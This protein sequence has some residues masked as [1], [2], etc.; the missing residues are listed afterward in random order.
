MGQLFVL[1]LIVQMTGKT[2]IFCHGWSGHGSYLWFRVLI[3]KL[4]QAGVKCLS[5]DFPDAKD[6]RYPDWHAT[7]LGMVEKESPENDIYFVCHSMGGYLLLR[8]LGE[9][10]QAE[11]ISKCKGAVIVA[12]P[13]TKRPEYKPFYDAEIDWAALRTVSAKLIFIHCWEDS[14]VLEEHPK[15]LLAHLGDWPNAEFAFVEGFDH[16]VCYYLPDVI[17]DSALRILSL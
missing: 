8:F 1:N 5:P 9:H 6:P 3:P 10:S 2:V 15:N 11:W 12:T 13:S 7:L 14:R 16:F 4:E 17:L